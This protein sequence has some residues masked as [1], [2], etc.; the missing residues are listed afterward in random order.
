MSQ[1]NRDKI[2]SLFYPRVSSKHLESFSWEQSLK[3]DEDPTRQWFAETLVD[4]LNRW[5]HPQI[6]DLKR[7]GQIC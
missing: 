2:K 7:A 5:K 3:F 6:K 1:R 4:E